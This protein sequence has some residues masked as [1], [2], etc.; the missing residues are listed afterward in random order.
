VGSH[1]PFEEWGRFLPE[2][3]TA[4]SMLDRLLHHAVVVVTEES[5]SGC[6]RLDSEEV[7]GEQPDALG[8]WGLLTGHQWGLLVGR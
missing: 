8:G 7:A 5:P 2:H 4:V 6:G 1:W 3:T